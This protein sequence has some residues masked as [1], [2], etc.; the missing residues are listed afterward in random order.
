VESRERYQLL[1]VQVWL[2]FESD[3]CLDRGAGIGAAIGLAIGTVVAGVQAA[4][5]HFTAKGHEKE[6][7]TGAANQFSDFAWKDL[8]PGVQSGSMTGA[9]AMQSLVK[10]H[11]EYNN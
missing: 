3:Q 10:A 9:A 6:T 8:I 7:A 11:E 4:I 2:V 5:G 1:V